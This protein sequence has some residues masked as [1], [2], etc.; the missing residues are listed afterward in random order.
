MSII[1]IFVTYKQ[2]FLQ[3]LGITLKLCLLVWSI[4]ISLGAILGVL[5]AKFHSSFG[6]I[7]KIASTLISGCPIIVLMYW[8][9][10]PMQHQLGIEIPPFNVAV[11]ALSIVNIFIVMDLVKNAIKDL[12]NQYLLSARVSGLSERTTLFQI[13]IPLIFKQLIGPVLLVQITMLHNS[14]FASLINVGEIFRQIQRINALVYKPIELYT[15][16]AIFFIAITVPLTLLAQYLK[17]RYAKN[18]S[19]R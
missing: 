11:M 7:S 12:P 16:L 1:E 14:I 18:Y 2:G 15:T 3:S 5:S 13:Q 6:L 17:K 4:G 9:Y 10:Y 19:E 8:L